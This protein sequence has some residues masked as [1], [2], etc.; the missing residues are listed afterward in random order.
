[1]SSALPYSAKGLLVLPH[2]RVQSANAISSQMTHGFP[3]ITAFTG[4][5]WA[6]ER[7]LTNTGVPL[8]LQKVGVICH[9][10]QEQVNDGYMKTFRLTRNP[11][12]RTGGTAAIV[13][14]GRTHLDLTLVFQ[15]QQK[16]GH[17]DDMPLLIQGNDDA[18]AKLATKA[19]QT[20]ANM[21]VAGGSVL[22][23]RPAP[24][25]FTRPWLAVLP[26]DSEEL[27]RN[28]RAWRRQWLPGYA[29]VGRD[30]LMPVR[31]ERL[32][33]KRPDATTLD[34]WLDMSRFNY[35]AMQDSDGATGSR[36][37]WHDPDRGKGSGWIVPI[38]VGYASLSDLHEPG[39]VLNARDGDTPMR[40]VESIYSMGE[41]IGPHRLDH[42][43][44]LLWQAETDLERGVY[45]C[46]NGYIASDGPGEIDD[47]FYAY[48]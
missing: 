12:D 3:S 6:L 28:F 48:D 15:V 27:N 2:L 26:D 21:R 17:G 45:R 20:L 44:A 13:E 34:A 16:A 35:R 37:H 24:G 43:D 31:L 5:M 32:R 22:P 10:H 30:D 1:M 4:L 8:R 40:F 18:L 11:V 41:W 25:R 33:Q 29:L 42:L 7:K 23:S 47:D 19:L 36:V 9:H 46:R 38:P 39:K 14:E